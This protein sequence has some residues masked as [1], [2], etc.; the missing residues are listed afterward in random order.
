MKLGYSLRRWHTGTLNLMRDT[1]NLSHYLMWLFCDFSK[2]K[3]IKTKNIKNILVIYSGH[4]GDMSNSTGIINELKNKNPELNFYYL[5]TKDRRKFVTLPYVVLINKQQA[6]KLIR[7]KKIDAAVL[8]HGAM[9]LRDLFDFELYR[10]IN[11]VPY[12]VSCDILQISPALFLRQI[13]PIQLTRKIF[14]LNNNSFKHHLKCFQSLGFEVKKTSFYFT[15]HG[16][17]FAESFIKKNKIKKDE[18]VVFLHPGSGKA[19]QALE[20]NKIASSLWVSQRWVDVADY[21]IEKYNARIIIT[22]VMKERA[23]ADK[24]YDKIKNKKKV[25]SLVGK[26]SIEEIASLF[27][28]SSLIISI[29]TAS[30]HIGAQVG[31]PVVDLFGPL[32]P[33]ECSP[34]GESTDLFHREVCTGCRKY[35]CPEGNNICMKS[36]TVEEVLKAADKYLKT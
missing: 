29:D 13:I 10:L 22:G 24:I 20:E 11:R 19:V 7:N 32:R 12:R 17:K 2:F 4:V 16:E 23:I 6:K 26:T 35:A 5:T 36:I 3:R 27:K 31:V 30:A 9:A 1:I 8:L 21:L 33:I 28:R 18:K 34:L 15:T 25:I 14:T